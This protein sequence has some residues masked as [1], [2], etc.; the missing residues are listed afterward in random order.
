MRWRRDLPWALVAAVVAVDGALLLADGAYR[1]GVQPFGGWRWNAA[2]DAGWFELF[3]GVQLVGA[4]VVLLVVAHRLER[5]AVLRWWALA[6]LVLAVDDNAGLH[7]SAGTAAV[8]LL[9]LRRVAGVGAQDQGELIVLM[10]GALALAAVL[11]VPHHRGGDAARAISRGVVAGVA[12]MV[13][14]GVVVDAVHAVAVQDRASFANYA[15]AMVEAAGESLGAGVVL[16]VSVVALRRLV[17]WPD[18]VRARAD[19]V[20]AAAATDAAPT[21]PLAA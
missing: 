10:T 17:G 14:F 19:A 1:V 11:A 12:V 5:A 20:T 18:G 7:E 4:A 15:F 13:L 16:V 21:G 2:L 3:R 6:F 9:G 8:H